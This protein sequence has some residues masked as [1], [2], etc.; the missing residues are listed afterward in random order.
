MRVLDAHELWRKWPADVEKHAGRASKTPPS[1]V[2]CS[3]ASRPRSCPRSRFVWHF[4]FLMVSTTKT[5]VTVV[6]TSAIGSICTGNDQ[7]W[8]ESGKLVLI[9][10]DVFIL[11]QC[12]LLPVFV[13]HVSFIPRAFW[14]S[15]V[16]KGR[17]SWKKTI[18]TIFIFWLLKPVCHFP[19]VASSLCFNMLFLIWL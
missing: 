11:G 12:Y 14:S 1:P 18:I 2:I 7:T 19:R 10:G 3:C 9:A 13:V 16:I 17:L 15:S 6:F 4:I 8:E 5:W